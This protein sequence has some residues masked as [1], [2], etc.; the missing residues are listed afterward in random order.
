MHEEGKEEEELE[1]DVDLE[2]SPSK[3]QQAE[4]DPM[5]SEPTRLS[6]AEAEAFAKTW[7]RAE[8]LVPVGFVAVVVVS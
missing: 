5:R 2:E 1:S 7:L 6:T 3:N 4:F 8:R